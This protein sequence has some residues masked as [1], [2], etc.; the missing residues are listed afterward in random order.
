MQGF[1]STLFLALHADCNVPSSPRLRWND[2]TGAG[3]NPGCPA[4]RP[5]PGE[6][7]R[8]RVRHAALQFTVDGTMR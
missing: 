8:P 4:A 6:R 1:G 2:R 7:L 3:V 5:D